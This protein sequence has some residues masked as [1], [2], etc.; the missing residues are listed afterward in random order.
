MIIGIGN[1]LSDIRRIEAVME[2]YGP[3]F[4]QRV[5]TSV[6]QAKANGRVTK[7]ATLAKRFAAKE[8]CAKAVFTEAVKRRSMIAVKKNSRKVSRISGIS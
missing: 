8:A 3:R 1:D 4:M 2:K 7:A 6:E 5:F